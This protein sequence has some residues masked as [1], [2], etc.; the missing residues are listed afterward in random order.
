MAA[1]WASSTGI[2]PLAALAW[3]EATM[4]WADCTAVVSSSRRDSMICDRCCSNELTAINSSATNAVASISRILPLKLSLLMKSPG[5]K[6][7]AVLGTQSKGTAW[8]VGHAD[9]LGLAL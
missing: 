5:M 1:F 9:P 8:V 3:Y 4:L 7:K 2:A 6:K